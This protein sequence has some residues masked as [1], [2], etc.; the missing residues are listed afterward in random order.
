[1]IAAISRQWSCQTP[2]QDTA[3]VK[4]NGW[5]SM[6][7]TCSPGGRMLFLVPPAARFTGKGVSRG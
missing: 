7:L 2:R 1:M 5:I 4:M 6:I 3:L